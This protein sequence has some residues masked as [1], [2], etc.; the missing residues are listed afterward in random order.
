MMAER[1][2]VYNEEDLPI[3][4]CIIKNDKELCIGIDK[5]RFHKIFI[6]DLQRKYDIHWREIKDE[7]KRT[8]TSRL[9]DKFRDKLKDAK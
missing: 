1:K 9:L 5:F 7:S 3:E 6:E 2:V 4:L 8:H